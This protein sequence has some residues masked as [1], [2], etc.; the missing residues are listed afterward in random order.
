MALKLTQP[1]VDEH[2][3]DH[4]YLC[5]RCKVLKR[6]KFN[7]LTGE[8]EGFYVFHRLPELLKYKKVSKV[9]RIGKS[10]SLDPETSMLKEIETTTQVDE[11]EDIVCADC[12]HKDPQFK[13]DFNL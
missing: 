8:T 4:I 7:A 6:G 2:I 5:D 13:V 12:L 11:A 3:I 1:I 9:S 10:V